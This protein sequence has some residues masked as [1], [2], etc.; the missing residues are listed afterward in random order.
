MHTPIQL[1]HNRDFFLYQWRN[2]HTYNL[3]YILTATEHFILSYTI[4]KTPAIVVHTIASIIINGQILWFI[5]CAKLLDSTT[6]SFFEVILATFWRLFLVVYAFHTALFSLS[7][8]LKNV[9]M[10]INLKF[11][12]SLHNIFI[13]IENEPSCMQY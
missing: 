4:P 13:S 5:A 8:W 1:L 10:N 6:T 7:E 11:S 12:W 9:Q 2:R 3:L